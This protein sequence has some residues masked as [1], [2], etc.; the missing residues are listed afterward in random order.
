MTDDERKKLRELAE[1]ATPGPWRWGHHK[2]MRGSVQESMFKLYSDVPNSHGEQRTMPVLWMD[3]QTAAVTLNDNTEYIAAA[4]PQAVVALLDEVERLQE[5]TT[6]GVIASSPTFGKLRDQLAAANAEIE[7]LRGAL[8]FERDLYKIE[9]DRADNN[10]DEAARLL[11]KL[12]SSLDTAEQLDR[13]LQAMT[14]ARDEACE[15]AD[16]ICSCSVYQKRLGHWVACDARR[17][18]QLRAVGG[19]K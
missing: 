15:I 4:N 14:A 3:P 18:A 13:E 7:R 19:D 17:I 12:E 2:N 16:G 11:A 6:V 10:H 5:R 9:H 8:K 1:A